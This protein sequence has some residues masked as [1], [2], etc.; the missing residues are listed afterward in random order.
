M[1]A[2]ILKTFYS[3]DLKKLRQEITLY[4]NENAIWLTGKE[5]TNSAGNLCLHLAGNLNTYIG[6]VLGNT[7]Y[8]RNRDLEFSLKNI[9][10]DE[11]IKKID[12]TIAVVEKVCER[13]NDEQLA[14]EYPVLVWDE[15]TTTG[16]L[17]VHLATHLAYHLG[18]VNYHRR[19]LDI[20]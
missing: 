2:Q 8:T 6:A 20:D 5:I 1:V 12:E 14:E 3:R 19:L 9:A 15:K 18:Q 17:L 13:V 10:R 16:F 11:L 7:G 4:K